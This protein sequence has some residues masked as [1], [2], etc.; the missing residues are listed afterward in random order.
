MDMSGFNR[1]LSSGEFDRALERLPR[2]LSNEV[3]TMTRAVMVER[4]PVTAVAAEWNVTRQYVSQRVAQIWEA[5]Q[6]H[7]LPPAG[8]VRFEACLPEDMVSV[9]REMEKQARHR[10]N[11]S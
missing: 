3:L 9:V 10:L 5:H 7:G 1:Y 6:V 2:P 8:W 4:K 11:K